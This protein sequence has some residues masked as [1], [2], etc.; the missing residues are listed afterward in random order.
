M[1]R[2]FNM[3]GKSRLSIAVGAIGA[4]VAVGT[5][6]VAVAAPVVVATITDRLDSAATNGLNDYGNY[7][8]STFINRVAG[9]KHWGD[10]IQDAQDPFDTQEIKITRDDAAK[11][12]TFD[13][14]TY[15]NGNDGITH[16]PDLFIDTGTANSSTNRPDHFN[17]AISLGEEVSNG[18]MYQVDSLGHAILDS[19]GNKIGAKGLYSITSFETS[20]DI[21]KTRTNYVYGGY[22]QFKPGTAGYDPNMALVPPT[23]LTA[24]MLQSAYT[25]STSKTV[26]GHDSTLNKDIYDLSVV[27]TSTTN[28]NLFNNFDVFWGTGDCSNDAIWGQ[29]AS[30]AV[31]APS[32]LLLMG[33]GLA[34]LA[35]TRRRRKAAAR[36]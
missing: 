20:Q 33:F 32:A 21:W 28:L 23:V 26:I 35:E 24:G 14:K 6:N 13:M 18:G 16:Y 25:V 30:N 36:V 15:F 11:T 17:Y 8:S 3:L 34:G 31:P 10:S 29:V 9:G 12:I 7:S 27:V 1:V 22:V 19:H 4:L 2:G 5:M